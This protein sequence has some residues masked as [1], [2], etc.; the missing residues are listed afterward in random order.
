MLKRFLWKYILGVWLGLS[1][2]WSDPMASFYLNDGKCSGSK[3]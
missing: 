3:L 2:L 1:W